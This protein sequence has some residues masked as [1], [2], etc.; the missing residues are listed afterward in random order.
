[1]G[2]HED[3]SVVNLALKNIRSSSAVLDAHLADR[4]FMVGDQLTLADIDT[5]APFSQVGRSKV[6]FAE[7][8]TSGHSSNVF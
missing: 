1:M 5:V 4:P 8:Q 3:P 2:H 6:P 7:F